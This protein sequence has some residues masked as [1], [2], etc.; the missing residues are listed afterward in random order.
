MNPRNAKQVGGLW[1]ATHCVAVAAWG[2]VVT[3]GIWSLW[4][5]Q[6]KAGADFDLINVWPQ[7]SKIP[8]DQEQH[9]LVMFVHPLCPCSRASIAELERALTRC[10][11]AFSAVVMFV[12]P[13]GMRNGWEKSDL[14]DAAAQVPGVHVAWDKDGAEA[15]RFGAATSGLAVL[16]DAQGKLVFRGGLT[17]SR[18]HHGNSPGRLAVESLVLGHT[19]NRKDSRVF[20]CPLGSTVTDLKAEKALCCQP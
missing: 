2:V 5:Y 19:T 14:W 16:Y 3:G 13:G 11:L 12:R 7:E 15:S 20:G 10:K 8:R 18:G 17:S 6:H 9:T 1:L 4:L